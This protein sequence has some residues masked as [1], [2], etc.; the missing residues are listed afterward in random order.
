M[1]S[2]RQELVFPPNGTHRELSSWGFAVECAKSESSQESKRLFI[3]TVRKTDFLGISI[4]PLFVLD[5]WENLRELKSF[6]S[7]PGQL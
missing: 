6:R 7:L 3:V 4:P 1:E 5:A 2:T